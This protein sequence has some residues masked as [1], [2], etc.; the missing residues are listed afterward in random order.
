MPQATDN[1]PIIHC[2]DLPN[3]DTNVHSAG[4]GKIKQG[5]AYWADAQYRHG[6]SEG[7]TG[8]LKMMANGAPVQL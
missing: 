5:A 4:E 2:L 1:V 8:T 7:P 3:S 6:T